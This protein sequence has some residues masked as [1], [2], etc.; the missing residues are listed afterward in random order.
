MSEDLTQPFGN[1]DVKLILSLLRSM[2]ARLTSL[3]G[4]VD[5]RLKETRPIWELVVARL[6]RLETE[7]AAFKE[8]VNARLDNLDEKVENLGLDMRAGFKRLERQIAVLAKDIAGVRA[9]QSDLEARMDRL[10][11]KLDSEHA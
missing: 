1:D 2:D 7:L 10:E 4:T 8:A 3:E 9:D 5:K 11:D 6:D